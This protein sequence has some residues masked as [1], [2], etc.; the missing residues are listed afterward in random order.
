MKHIDKYDTV[1]YISISL[2]IYLKS[3][4]LLLLQIAFCHSIRGPPPPLEML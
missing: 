1:Y 3:F 2:I 4:K